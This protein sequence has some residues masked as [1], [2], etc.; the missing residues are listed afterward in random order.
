MGLLIGIMLVCGIF[1]TRTLACDGP[2]RNLGQPAGSVTSATI[3]PADGSVWATGSNG[4][5]TC[6]DG[7]T[8]WHFAGLATQSVFKLT[9]FPYYGPNVFAVTWGGLYMR[10]ADTTWVHLSAPG[11]GYY[12]QRDYSI[13]PYDTS[14]RVC[15]NFSTDFGSMIYVSRNSGQD[16]TNIY[17]E[18]GATALFTNLTW[19]RTLENV[20]YFI[21]GAGVH[22]TN[23]AD[24]TTRTLLPFSTFLPLAV[25]SHP[26]QPWVYAAAGTH[27]GR[28][29]EA[30]DDTMMAPLPPGVTNIMN[31]A[32]TEEGLLANTD[33]GFF[34][35]SDDLATWQPDSINTVQAYLVYTSADRCLGVTYA[36]GRAGVYVSSRPNAVHAQQNVPASA[37]LGV[38]PNPF[39]P[40]TEIRFDLPQAA[41][42]ELKVYNSLGQLVSTLLDET[43]AAG[44]YSIPW[45]GQNHA[46]G[47]YFCQIKAGPFTATRKMLLLK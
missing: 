38:Y 7:D 33:Q 6:A 31:I 43:R 20:F 26:Q 28:Y 15:S 30:A 11:G 9:C 10:L 5:Y 23:L 46:T 12:Q 18:E 40:T 36:A 24:S 1:G 39:N 41:R 34:H 35:V 17:E 13:C 3:N 2:W 27:I 14:L 37:Q 19:S 8:V 29:D 21:G 47:L 32:Y 44:S 45:N 4:I 42:V 22:Q 16:W 25:A